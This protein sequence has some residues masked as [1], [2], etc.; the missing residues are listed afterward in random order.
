M[1]QICAFDP[2]PVDD[3]LH[4]M[5]GVETTEA[6]S[7]NF[8]MIGYESMWFVVNIGS[9]AFII[10]FSAVLLTMIP[11]LKYCNQVTFISKFRNYLKSKVL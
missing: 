1:M 5:T 6:F 9:L 11:L 3:I 2:L 7:F 10:L 4:D 8:E